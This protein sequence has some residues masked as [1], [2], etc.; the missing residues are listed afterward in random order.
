M[1]GGATNKERTIAKLYSS[2]SKHKSSFCALRSIV[3]PLKLPSSSVNTNDKVVHRLQSSCTMELDDA[4]AYSHNLFHSTYSYSTLQVASS[5]DIPCH[6]QPEFSSKIAA[7]HWNALLL[8]AAPASV[9][10]K[11]VKSTRT[12]VEAHEMDLVQAASNR[13]LYDKILLLV[14][15]GHDESQLPP[16][17]PSLS[18][19]VEENQFNRYKDLALTGR[20]IGQTHNLTRRVATFCNDETKLLPELVVAAPLRKSI[21]TVMVAF[22]HYSPDSMRP[23]PWV[24]H[25]D[26]AKDVDHKNNKNDTEE[27][28][29]FDESLALVRSKQELLQRSDRFVQWLQTRE[30]QVIVGTYSV[31]M[32]WC[33]CLLSE[34][35]GSHCVP[36][37]V[38]F[39]SVE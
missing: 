18:L 21:H 10:H 15:H 22:A 17:P 28:T 36:F 37:I 16:L 31:V 23:I 39:N 1:R 34:R 32:V 25:P 7:Q 6:L 30:E 35:H 26:A 5:R 9:Q 33:C 12:A 8:A 38:F 27:E 13:H 20:G 3:S 2:W 19:P 24:C 14:K 11:Q 4:D 29:A